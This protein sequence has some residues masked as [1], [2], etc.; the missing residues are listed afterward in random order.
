MVRVRVTTIKNGGIEMNNE[1]ERLARIKQK[2]LEYDY[3][4]G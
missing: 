4:S 2:A 1:Q 3:H